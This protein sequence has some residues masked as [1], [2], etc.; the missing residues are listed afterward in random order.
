MG[1]ILMDF[2][3]EQLEKEM[4]AMTKEMS[5][6][7]IAAMEKEIVEGFGQSF[8]DIFGAD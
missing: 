5:L 7:E 8:E 4:D 2:D 1:G 6:E 3:L